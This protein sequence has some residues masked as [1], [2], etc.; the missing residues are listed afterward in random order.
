MA[1]NFVDNINNMLAEKRQRLRQPINDRQ[2]NLMM[3]IMLLYFLSK[4]NEQR[5]CLWIPWCCRSA[6]GFCYV[7]YGKH[8]IGVIVDLPSARDFCISIIDDVHMNPHRL[9]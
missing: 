7:V 2:S 6:A 1:P 5:K 8:D 3:K 4:L 9:C